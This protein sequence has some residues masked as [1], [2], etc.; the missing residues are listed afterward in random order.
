MLLLG[1]GAEK[2]LLA[3]PAT[4]PC[5][6]HGCSR[7]SASHGSSCWQADSDGKHVQG[8][9]ARLLR[10]WGL[11][12][13]SCFQALLQQLIELGTASYTKPTRASA[14]ES[15]AATWKAED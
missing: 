14:I 1:S 3:P 4:E 11:A 8:C 12:A 9:W 5:C 13:G 15:S 2:L 10:P 7:M 6:G